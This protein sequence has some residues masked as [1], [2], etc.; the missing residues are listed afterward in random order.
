MAHE[1]GGIDAVCIEE[2]LVRIWRIATSS[3]ATI[4]L[5]TELAALQKDVNQR[6]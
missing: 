3:E 1:T 4:L 5:R 6:D 2:H